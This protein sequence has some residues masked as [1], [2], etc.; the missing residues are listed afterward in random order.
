MDTDPEQPEPTHTHGVAHKKSDTFD[1]V[2]MIV[3]RSLLRLYKTNWL[4]YMV[5]LARV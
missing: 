5:L 1:F 4:N 3:L 2:A